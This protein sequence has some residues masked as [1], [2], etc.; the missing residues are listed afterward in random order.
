MLR[1]TLKLV[2][3]RANILRAGSRGQKILFAMEPS[4]ETIKWEKPEK[5]HW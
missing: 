3:L 4:I 2:N 5:K 1:D